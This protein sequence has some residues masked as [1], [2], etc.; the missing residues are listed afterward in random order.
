MNELIRHLSFA[1]FRPSAAIEWAPAP[2]PLFRPGAGEIHLW[3]ATLDGGKDPSCDACLSSDEQARAD[4][5]RAPLHRDRF[6]RARAI[7]RHV[8]AEHLRRDAREVCFQY[9]PHGKPGLVDPHLKR[10]DS[11]EFNLSH[12]G[13]MLLLGICDRPI[14]VD[15]ECVSDFPELM[16][17]ARRVFSHAMV[18]D[19]ESRPCSG[20]SR[21][22]FE[23][24]TH[25]EARLKASGLGLG[26]LTNPPC[27]QA[28]I[29][30]CPAWSIAVAENYQ[31]AVAIV[32]DEPR[33]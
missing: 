1:I 5:L 20:R 24:W 11:L 18:D 17:V 21:A 15:I 16:S 25:Q 13:G 7:L 30:I 3:K 29:P 32:T 31:A 19:L 9:G 6:I 10:G 28:E 2:A 27:V 8:L 12:S 26:A 33:R 22:F 23:A 4:R 14:G